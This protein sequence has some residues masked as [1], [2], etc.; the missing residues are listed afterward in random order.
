MKRFG[1]SIFL[2]ILI[3]DTPLFGEIG[4]HSVQSEYNY[5]YITSEKEDPDEVI[6]Y[7]NNFVILYQD[8]LVRTIPGNEGRYFENFMYHYY[9]VRSYFV[10]NI[11]KAVITITYNKPIFTFEKGY[12]IYLKFEF[13]F[14]PPYEIDK[15]D[16]PEYELIIQDFIKKFDDYANKNADIRMKKV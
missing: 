3:F 2:I 16:W 12:I 5:S 13:R 14:F 9:V 15:K 4:D 11:V 6:E 10:N 7:F 1:F 8:E